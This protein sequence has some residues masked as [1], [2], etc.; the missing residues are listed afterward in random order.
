MEQLIPLVIQLI[1]GAAGGNIIGLI[2]ALPL[3]KIIATIA[4]LIGGVGGG[5]LAQYLPALL[6]LFGDNPNV[7]SG[8]ASAGGGAVLTLIV[9]LIKK[10]MA[11][12]AA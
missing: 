1:G 8:V 6:Q 10:A 2:K 11:A 4:G 5:Q 7:G 3:N 12:K 9:G